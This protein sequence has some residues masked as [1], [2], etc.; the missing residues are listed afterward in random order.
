MARLGPTG[1]SELMGEIL[2][3][4][5]KSLAWPGVAIVLAVVFR[6]P[7]GRLIDRVLHLK[8]TRDG[9]EVNTDPELRDAIASEAEQLTSS[10][11]DQK[12]M[13]RIIQEAARAGFSLA[14]TGRATQ[15]PLV[16]LTWSKDGHL[17]AVQFVAPPHRRLAHLSP[18]DEQRARQLERLIERLL[19]DPGDNGDEV[20]RLRAG[21][22][23]L[24][25]FSPMLVDMPI[26][27]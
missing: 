19:E 12:A 13:E 22:R 26:E 17:E 25:P 16:D 2:A 14:V 20:A 27:E 5:V 24:D 11:P 4:L 3:D 8:V 15:P 18:R 23:A 10:R 1:G 21:L 9:L 6:K 7:L